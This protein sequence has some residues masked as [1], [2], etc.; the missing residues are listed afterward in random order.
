MTANDNR[1]PSKNAP[2]ASEIAKSG[3]PNLVLHTPGGEMPDADLYSVNIS[4]EEV[5]DAFGGAGQQ[6]DRTRTQP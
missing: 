3:R 5:N 2:A 4:A 1:T 6:A